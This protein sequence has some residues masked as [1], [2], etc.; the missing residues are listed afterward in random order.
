MWAPFAGG[1]EGDAQGAT[2]YFIGCGGRLCTLG[3]MK[4]PEVMRCVLLCIL[5]VLEMPGVMCCVLLC[6]LEVRRS[7]SLYAGGCGGWTPYA[8]GA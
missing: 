7:D 1:A 3:V 8:G 4:V 2:L 6:L 5:D